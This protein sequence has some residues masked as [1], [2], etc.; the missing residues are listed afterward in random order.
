MQARFSLCPEGQFLPAAATVGDTQSRTGGGQTM[1]TA[2]RSVR[3]MSIMLLIDMPAP[4][5]EAW[6]GRPQ[7]FGQSRPRP[8]Q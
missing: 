4:A 6:S 8:H 3:I 2:R 7:Q 5:W 1:V